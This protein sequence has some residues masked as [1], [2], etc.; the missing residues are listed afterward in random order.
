[1][2]N[3]KLLDLIRMRK[4]LDGYLLYIPGD[5]SLLLNQV[6]YEIL[7]LCNGDNSMD[8]IINTISTRYGAEREIARKDVTTFLKTFERIKILSDA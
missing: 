8:S 3:P 5:K 2:K 6:G 7:A 4:D 1:M